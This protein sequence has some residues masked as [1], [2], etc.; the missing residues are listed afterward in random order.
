RDQRDSVQRSADMNNANKNEKE[1]AVIKNELKNR[2][3]M[4]RK[5]RKQMRGKQEQEPTLG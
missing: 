4:A 5:V 2:L 1:L 3:L